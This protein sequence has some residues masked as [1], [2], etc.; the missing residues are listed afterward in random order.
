MNQDPTPPSLAD[1]PYSRLGIDLVFEIPLALLSLIWFKLVKLIIAVIYGVSL[2]LNRKLLTQ[3]QVFSDKTLQI[4]IVLPVVM[5]KG[6][7]WNPHAVVVS[8]GPFRVENEFSIDLNALRRSAQSWTIVVYR[9]PSY[10]TVSHI[11]ALDGFLL[12][13]KGAFQRKQSRGKHRTTRPDRRL[14]GRR[15]I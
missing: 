4:P 5:T 9:Y 6:P 15:Q 3:W 8:V 7:R 12:R 14:S 2:A 1:R 10:Q 11:S 13:S